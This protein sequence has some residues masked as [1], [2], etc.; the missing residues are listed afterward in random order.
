[1]APHHSP[2]LL[3]SPGRL[4]R[5]YRGPLLPMICP[6]TGVRR[7][8]EPVELGA[9]LPEDLRPVLLPVRR[10]PLVGQGLRVGPRR[11]GVRVV[12]R[13]HDVVDADVV[14]L[15]QTDGVLHERG[16]HLPGEVVARWAP[17]AP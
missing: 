17:R 4:S 16:E 13:P 8:G 12:A 7:S 2:P 11:L 14:A 3:P 1:V 10:E 6:L 9:V 15:A 5:S